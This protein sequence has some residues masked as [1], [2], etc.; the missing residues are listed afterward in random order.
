[1]NAVTLPFVMNTKGVVYRRTIEILE[2]QQVHKSLIADLIINCQ[3]SLIKAM[4]QSYAKLNVRTSDDP[5]CLNAID[6]PF[7]DAEDDDNVADP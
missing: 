5:D 3:C 1:M 6:E 2:K 7:S 4:T